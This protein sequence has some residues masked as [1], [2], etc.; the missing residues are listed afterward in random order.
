MSI[1]GLISEGLLRKIPR[2]PDLAEKEFKESEYDFAKAKQALKGK[3][4][5][6]ATIAAYYSMFHAAKGVLFLLG[7]K[8]KS[9]YAVSEVLEKLNKAGKLESNYVDDFRAAMSSREGAD[10]RYDH[11]GETAEQVVKIAEEFIARMK[12][13]KSSL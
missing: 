2:S 6:W 1:E 7:L 10:Y 3:D 5:K 9:H 11:S 4:A 8:E 13:L 12:K